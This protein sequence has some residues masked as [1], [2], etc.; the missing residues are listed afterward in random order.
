MHN[1]KIFFFSKKKTFDL[2][3]LIPFSGRA[4]EK[5]KQ[6]LEKMIKAASGYRKKA[7]VEA[8]CRKEDAVEGVE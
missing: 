7:I 8:I 6:I 5:D 4:L 3:I 2:L 1:Q